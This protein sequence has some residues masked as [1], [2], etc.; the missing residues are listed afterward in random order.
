MNSIASSKSFSFVN[1]DFIVASSN[2]PVHNPDV[3]LRFFNYVQ[4][5]DF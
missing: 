1:A 4:K 2:D 5:K 3:H